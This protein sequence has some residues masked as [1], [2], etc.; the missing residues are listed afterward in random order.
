MIFHPRTALP[1]LALL[2]VLAT[3]GLTACGSGDFGAPTESSAATPDDTSTDA[4][5]DGTQE[6]ST[7]QV[8]LRLPEG[9]KTLDGA[10]A[11][12]ENDGE[13]NPALTTLAERL[14]V[15]RDQL[16]ATMANM[17]LFAVSDGGARR[18]ILTN[19][20][21]LHHPDDLPNEAQLALQVARF[22]DSSGDVT[23]V[24]SALGDVLRVDYQL[25]INGTQGQ[26]ELLLTQV[27]DDLVAITVTSADADD[28]AEVADLVVDSLEEA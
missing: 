8:R 5:T 10:E 19:L 20:N 3:G 16:V 18:G 22:A 12:Q 28:A 4:G 1:T 24:D 25:D 7:E 23:T 6:V 26:F 17:D 9:W 2:A 13:K 21:V 11:L 27:G 15:P 14:G